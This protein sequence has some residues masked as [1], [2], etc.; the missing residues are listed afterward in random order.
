MDLLERLGHVAKRA[1]LLELLRSRAFAEREVTLSSGAKSNF[2]I[3]CKQV[4]LDAEG[5]SLIG[6]LFHAV[7]DELAPSAVAVGGLTLGA[8]PLATATSLASFLAGRPRSAFIVRKEPKGHGTNQWVECTQ[9]AAG[10]PVVVLE[11]VVTTGAAT[12][13]AIERTREAGFVPI[14]AVAIV[15]RLEGGRDAITAHL[16]LTTLFTRHDF[17]PERRT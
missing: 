9:L 5:A 1:R 7:I 17:L 4:S 11:D 3:D 6:E 14:H 8:D 12:L 15:D 13:K 2:Y 16:P 10:A